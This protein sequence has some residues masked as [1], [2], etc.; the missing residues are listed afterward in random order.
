MVDK[1]IWKILCMVGGIIGC[2][3]S[4]VKLIDLNTQWYEL[5]ATTVYLESRLEFLMSE[6]ES[7]G[8]L[9]G[10]L[11]ILFVIIFY[12]GCKIKIEIK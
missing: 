12:I 4:V 10:L 11:L 7:Q 2:I 3:I 1:L 9:W 5:D 8:D 6:I